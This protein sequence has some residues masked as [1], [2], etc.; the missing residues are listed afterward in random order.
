MLPHV[1]VCLCVW[2]VCVCPGVL[3]GLFDI[4][5]V[6]PVDKALETKWSG[7]SAYCPFKRICFICP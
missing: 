2:C 6:S 3:F 7:T 5:L 4:Y 1:C